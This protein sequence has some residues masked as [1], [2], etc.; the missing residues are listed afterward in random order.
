MRTYVYKGGFE[1][2]VVVIAESH[3][4]AVKAIESEYQL[5]RIP[6]KVDPLLVT[7]IKGGSEPRTILFEYR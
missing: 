1:A 6:H 7:H 4:S 2:I 5:R 3:S